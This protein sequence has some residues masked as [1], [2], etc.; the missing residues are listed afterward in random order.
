MFDKSI[1]SVDCQ[2]FKILE[3]KSTSIVQKDVQLPFY[4]RVPNI[5]AN[6]FGEGSD[7]MEEYSPY[8][9]ELLA[10]NNPENTWIQNYR[11][12][13]LGK[14]DDSSWFGSF[15][16]G[17]TIVNDNGEE[18][19]LDD[20]FG[21]ETKTVTENESTETKSLTE[22]EVTDTSYGTKKPT[23]DDGMFDNIKV[24]EE[25][26]ETILNFDEEN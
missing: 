8:Y 7:E 2:S 16:S 3:N 21:S 22:N 13:A 10:Q 15:F 12:N 6:W 9:I 4:T 23:E 14:D 1:I 24:T 25:D 19:D 26:G 17:I 20:V 18:T 5:L 11:D